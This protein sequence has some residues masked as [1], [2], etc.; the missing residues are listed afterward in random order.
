MAISTLNCLLECSST[1]DISTPIDIF[2]FFSWM[3]FFEPSISKDQ[4]MCA[5]VVFWYF[6]ALIG[7]LQVCFYT[8]WNAR[9]LVKRKNLNWILNCLITI[10]TVTPEDVQKS[11][12]STRESVSQSSLFATPV[13]KGHFNFATLLPCFVLFFF[14]AVSNA[15]FSFW[16]CQQKSNRRPI[17]ELSRLFCKIRIDL[18]SPSWKTNFTQLPNAE[19]KLGKFFRSRFPFVRL[20]LSN[21]CESRSR[22]RFCTCQVILSERS[23]EVRSSNKENKSGEDEESERVIKHTDKTHKLMYNIKMTQTRYV[24]DENCSKEKKSIVKKS[25]PVL[26]LGNKQ[27]CYNVEEITMESSSNR[28]SWSVK[29]NLRRKSWPRT[30]DSAWGPT[31]ASVNVLWQNRHWRPCTIAAKGA[32]RC[33]KFPTIQEKHNIYWLGESQD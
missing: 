18:P 3:Y 26:K 5:C 7:D 16:F 13:T 24:S 33:G 10:T 9:D 30:K 17:I 32:T 6:L 19:N 22:R 27:K 1:F 21:S 25:Y 29:V 8:T 23:E 15:S 28:S 31:S 11:T 2:F 12:V 20:F 4:R 14:S